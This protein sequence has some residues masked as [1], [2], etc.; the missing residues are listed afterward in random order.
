MG[1]SIARK[2]IAEDQQAIESPEESFLKANS[3]MGEIP[4]DFS[5]SEDLDMLPSLDEGA[6]EAD[7]FPKYSLDD[8]P[9]SEPAVSGALGQTSEKTSAS[10]DAGNSKWDF[11]SGFGF[12][13]NARWRKACV[14]VLSVLVIVSGIGITVRQYNRTPAEPKSEHRVTKAVKRSIEIPNYQEQMELIVIVGGEKEN[15]LI[16]MQLEFAFP[17]E[18]AYQD[19][20]KDI[21][22]F[23]DLVYQFA[24]KERPTR[25]TQRAWQ[26]VVEKKLLSYLKST[27][28]KSGVHSIRIANW[29]RL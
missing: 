14:A 8:F 21:V 18:N 22:L 7:S 5:G 27:T 19:F 17:A 20:Q 25:N 29:E 24:S 6:S 2:A 1:R 9:T 13:F 12:L 23:R 28:P 11:L 4:D 15:S 26:E 3:R 16:S 10:P